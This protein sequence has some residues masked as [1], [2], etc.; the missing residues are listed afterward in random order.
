MLHGASSF[1]GFFRR[2]SQSAMDSGPM[3]A[4]RFKDDCLN[5]Y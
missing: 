4:I 5:D 2:D 3:E 1:F